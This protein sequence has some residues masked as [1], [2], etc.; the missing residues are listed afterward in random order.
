PQGRKLEMTPNI[1]KQWAKGKDIKV[2]DPAKLDTDVVDSLKNEN[3]KIFIV[4]SYG[5]IIPENII[6]IPEKKTLNIHP[7]LLPK[8]RGPSPLPSA[9][10][11]DMKHTGVTIMQ[12]DKEMDHGPIVAQTEINIEEWPIYE[13]FEEKMAS[14]GAELLVEIL[15]EWMNGELIAKEQD[16]AAT[17]YTKKVIKEDGL[18]NLCDNPYLNFRKIQA[19]HEWPQAYFIIKPRNRDLRV[20]ITAASFEEGKLK[21][22]KVIPEGGKEM[23][24]EDFLRGYSNPILSG[25]LP[26]R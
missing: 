4:A 1:V 8:Y 7:S 18:L 9:M 3:C 24:Y 5:E 15:P 12:I 10:L 19:Y 25:E 23:S 13:E 17:T 11:D 6:N 22:L 2:Y 14:A 20:K 21:M 26:A 16:H